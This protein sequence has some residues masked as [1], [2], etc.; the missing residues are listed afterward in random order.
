MKNT[1]VAVS[2][3]GKSNSYISD[4]SGYITI[5]FTKLNQGYM[6][7]AVTNPV[8]GEVKKSKIS[9]YSRFSG[10]KNIAMYYYDGTK[11]KMG[12]LGDDATFVGANQIVTIKL[13]KKTYK[14]KTDA[15][16]FITFKIPN[17]VKPGTYEL[18]AI[19]KGEI[20]KRTVK[21]KQNLKIKKYT[22][23]KSAKKL[24]IKATLKNGKKALK[25]KKITLK[26]NGK[27][28]TAKTN[29]KGI[30][31]FTIKKKFIKKLKK[32]KKYTMKVTYL[33]NTIKTTLKV[34]R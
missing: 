22:V 24:V 32:G 21:V 30:A 3:N 6:T 34:K 1:K 25:N 12:I 16:G 18:T 28:F 23:K 4:G 26:L 20:D 13:N 17:T 2:V 27:K 10:A 7:I 14:V 29:K 31:K 33:K 15:K 8:T 5:K 11:V 19:Y 9:V